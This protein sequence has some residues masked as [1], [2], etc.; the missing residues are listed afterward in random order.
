MY[1]KYD[2]NFAVFLYEYVN[3]K[4]AVWVISWKQYS[5][6]VKADRSIYKLIDTD[7]ISHS[8]S[9]DALIQDFAMRDCIE[10]SPYSVFHGDR[11]RPQA[12]WTFKYS[13]IPR[14]FFLF[15]PKA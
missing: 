10:A 6:K 1:S 13:Q 11:G 7:P 9:F 14:S 5:L 3:V 8:N 15:L 12:N 4:H 2:K